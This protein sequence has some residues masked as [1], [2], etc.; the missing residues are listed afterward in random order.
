MNAVESLRAHL[1][2]L[3]ALTGVRGEVHENG[4]QLYVVLDDVQLPANTFT[5]TTTDVLFITDR[6]YPLSAMDMFWVET[7]VLRA[8]GTVPQ[9]AD[10]IEHHLD[11]DWRRFSWHRNGIWNPSGNP[12]LDHYTLMET[13]LE[14]EP[15]NEAAA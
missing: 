4:M 7:D 5:R 2:E 13:R 10:V 8:D 3:A 1:A 11:R 12:L 9:A 6:Q 15:S 14:L